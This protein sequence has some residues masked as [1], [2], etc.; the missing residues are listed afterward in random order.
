MSKNGLVVDGEGWFVVNARD[1]RW[2]SEGPLGS[3]CT[4]EGKRRF[5]QLGINVNVLEPGQAMGMYHRERA[6]E[7]FLVLAGECVL[8]VEGQERR[9]E[10]WDFV[11]CPGGTEHII[12]ATG[13]RAAIV[14]AVGARGR[15]VGGGVVYTVS[16]LAARHGASVERETTSAAEA[17]EKVREDLPRSR[18]V[19][20]R[21]G[22]LPD[23][24]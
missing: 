10:S 22:W 9:L 1:S 8:I 13:D 14:V 19:E 5:P 7:G 23:D 21:E 17:Y 16:E 12:V 3:Y 11:H 24:N 4:F 6:Q 20:Y 2:R 18:W 15:G